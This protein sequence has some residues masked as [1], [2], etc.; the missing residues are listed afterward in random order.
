MSKQT[1]FSILAVLL[2]GTAATSCRESARQ[3][4][5][6]VY[7]L[8]REQVIQMDARL[9]PDSM[10][11]TFENGK[12]VDSGIQA[13]TS[14]FFP[15]SAWYVY[16]Y[17]GDPKV[18]EVA[19]RRTMELSPLPAFN[20][21]HD[22]GFMINCSFGNAWRITRDSTF[23]PTLAGGAANL[24]ARFNP[25]VGCTSSWGQFKDSK[26][27]VIIDNMMNLEILTTQARL[28]GADSLRDIAVSHANTTMK[29]HFRP[30]YTTWHVVSYDPET[31]DVA[32]K[33]THQGYSDDSAWA[34][35][36]AWGFYGYT[37][38]YRETGIPAY[39][40]QAENI[41]RM[42]L[43]RL[44]KDGV[45]YWDF[46]DP[47]IP[48]TQR[49]AS[50][51]AIMASAFTDL[52]GLTADGKLAKECRSMA[53]RQVRTLSSPAFLASGDNGHFLLRHSVGNKPGGAEIDVPLTYADYY[54]LEALKRLVE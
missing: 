47:D 16:E 41:A 46:D 2:I 12:T 8:A 24:A 29:N 18:R 42:L 14:G 49:D 35:G 23:L 13:W 10:P 22:I 3:I 27:T 45:P 36:Q 52:S 17:T 21:G 38:M 40:S 26:F 11:R 48:D 33:C 9:A 7:A 43:K 30:D 15:G 1:F 19:Q 28:S 20:V 25:T 54:F 50:A 39:L 53:L 5:D 51:G 31:G 32:F 37:M 4:S 6:R 44:P 34:R